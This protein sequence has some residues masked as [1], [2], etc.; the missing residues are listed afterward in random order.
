MFTNGQ[1]IENSYSLI[2]NAARRI[3]YKTLNAYCVNSLFLK[4]EANSIS[5]FVYSTNLDFPGMIF[6]QMPECWHL[7]LELTET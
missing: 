2:I 7:N 6:G 4:L 1:N 5:Y 3:N